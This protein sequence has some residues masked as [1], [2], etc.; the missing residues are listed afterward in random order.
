VYSRDDKSAMLEKLRDE[1]GEKG[2]DA[3]VV[4]DQLPTNGVTRG[5]ENVE[6]IRIYRASCIVYAK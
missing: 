1:A 3:V 6:Q 5:A 4:F 2:C